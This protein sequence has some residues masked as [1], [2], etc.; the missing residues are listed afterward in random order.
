MD[1][2]FHYVHAAII[3]LYRN[4]TSHKLATNKHTAKYNK[5]ILQGAVPK[6]EPF[7][8]ELKKKGINYKHQGKEKEEFAHHIFLLIKLHFYFLWEQT[9]IL[10]KT[11]KREK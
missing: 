7:Q 6:W 2:K 5:V 9:T 8:E 11:F 4:K 1:D 3:L 10:E